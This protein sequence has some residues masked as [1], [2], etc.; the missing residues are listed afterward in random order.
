MF[1]LYYVAKMKRSAFYWHHS[2]QFI[3]E[4]SDL[5][6]LLIIIYDYMCSVSGLLCRITIVS[7]F[8]ILQV[9]SYKF[10]R[11]N[12]AQF[13]IKKSVVSYD[14]S[15]FFASFSNAAICGLSWLFFI[16]LNDN[17]C[18][19]F[20]LPIWAH[21]YGFHLIMFV[22]GCFILLLYHLY[23]LCMCLFK[24]LSTWSCLVTCN[25]QQHFPG[26]VLDHTSLYELQ[27]LCAPAPLC[28]A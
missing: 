20:T 3:I 5:K 27:T 2:T 7:S 14:N 15:L 9:R 17:L 16:I 18:F 22:L 11:D 8:P 24:F 6:T 13:I 1:I 23:A 10:Y 4:K 12:S 21:F 28:I 25:I 26:Q 19:C